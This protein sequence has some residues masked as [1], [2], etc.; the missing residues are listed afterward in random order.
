MIV[1]NITYLPMCYFF[2]YDNIIVKVNSD[3]SN[4]Y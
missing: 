4:I 1:L 3:K 2:T